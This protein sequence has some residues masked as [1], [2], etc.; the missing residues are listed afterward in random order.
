MLNKY[1]EGPDEA[2]DEDGDDSSNDDNSALHMKLLDF[3][4]TD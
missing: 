1:R 2:D 4:R 3:G